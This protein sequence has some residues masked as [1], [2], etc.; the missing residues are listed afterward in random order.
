MASR[1]LQRKQSAKN[2]DVYLMAGGGIV[3]GSAF[4][5]GCVCTDHGAYLTENEQRA[6][7][8]NFAECF[9]DACRPWKR[10]RRAQAREMYK[11]I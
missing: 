11:A 3:A 8:R 5:F 2:R 9:S 6:F 10:H 7:I 1:T 4:P